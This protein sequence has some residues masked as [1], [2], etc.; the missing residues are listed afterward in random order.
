MYKRSEWS[1]IGVLTAVI[2]ATVPA[3]VSGQVSVGSAGRVG[4]GPVPAPQFDA[5]QAGSIVGLVRDAETGAPIAG[6]YVRLRELG[7]NELSH[8]DG[9]FHFHGVAARSY[10][11]VAQRIGYAPREERVRV[12]AG[13]TARLELSLTPSALELAGIVVTGTGR[14][15]GAGDTWQ[16]TTVVGE[17]ELR[18]RLESSVAATVAHVPGMAQRYNGP[19][20]AQP[21]IRGMG[22]D[23]VLVLE[24]GHRTGDL[25]AT[26]GDHAVAIEP[27]TA[28]RIEI[29]RGPAGLM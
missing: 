19:A 1:W 18:R 12:V 15:R 11:V 16:A 22:G 29:V 14:E 25:S 21:V 24:D 3:A 10:T 23:R 8:G 5:A 17:S 4:G 28:K 26:A 9:S 7:R 20:A 6:A 13:D 27:L 2:V